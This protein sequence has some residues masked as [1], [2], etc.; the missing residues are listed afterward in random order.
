MRIS[1][2]SSD[3]CSSDLEWGHCAQVQIK[4]AVGTP[5]GAVQRRAEAAVAQRQATVVFVTIPF[6]QFRK[7]VAHQA[8]LVAEL[9]MIVLLRIAEIGI[10]LELPTVDQPDAGGPLPDI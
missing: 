1:D 7:A 2:W 8:D 5:G 10:H 3:V 4:R 6:G 9:V